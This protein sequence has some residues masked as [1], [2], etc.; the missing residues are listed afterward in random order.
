MGYNLS[1]SVTGPLTRDN[2]WRDSIGVFRCKP[3]QAIVRRSFKKGNSVTKLDY[4][5]RGNTDRLCLSRY[6]PG[7]ETGR[8]VAFEVRACR[9]APKSNLLLTEVS[10]REGDAIATPA[11]K[12]MNTAKLTSKRGGD[13]PESILYPPI[14]RSRLDKHSLLSVGFF[15]PKMSSSLFGLDIC[16]PRRGSIEWNCWA[17]PPHSQNNDYRFKVT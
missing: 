8:Y 15:T 3:I 16:L 13:P 14:H 2:A 10:S 5:L 4:T 11:V 9:K 6:V 7:E 12:D 1:T 17:L